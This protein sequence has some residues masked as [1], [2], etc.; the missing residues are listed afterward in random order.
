MRRTLAP[1]EQTLWDVHQVARRY[2]VKAE[3]IQAWVRQGKFPQPLRF[4]RKCSRW[5]I[6]D[7]TTFEAEK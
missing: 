3:T 7:L 4:G 6:N 1:A 5:S 2:G